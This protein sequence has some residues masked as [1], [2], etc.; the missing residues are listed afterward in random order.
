EDIADIIARINSPLLG[1]CYDLS[2]AMAAGDDPV[3]GVRLLGRRLWAARI[4]DRD[5]DGSPC[6]LGEGELPC[7]DFVHALTWPLGRSGGRGRHGWGDGSWWR[8]LRTIILFTRNGVFEWSRPRG[9]SGRSGR[10]RRGGGRRPRLHSSLVRRTWP[11]RDPEEFVGLVKLLGSHAVHASIKQEHRPP[12]LFHVR[13]VCQ[14][15]V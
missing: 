8:G 14:N 2:A 15:N 11:A 6:M 12:L 5:A 4:K 13:K 3:A 9:C 10:G 1:A 7:R